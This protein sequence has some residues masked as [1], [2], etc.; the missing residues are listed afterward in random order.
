MKS[1]QCTIPR[2]AA[3]AVNLSAAL[4]GARADHVP[5]ARLE[6]SE[7]DTGPGRTDLTTSVPMA[8]YLAEQLRTLMENA[9][10]RNDVGLMVACS[11]GMAALVNAID[12]AKRA[13]GEPNVVAAKRDER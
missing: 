2:A 1:V 3:N 5:D 13:P 10:T 7:T 12:D 11:K 8:I 9:E 6:Y 4:R